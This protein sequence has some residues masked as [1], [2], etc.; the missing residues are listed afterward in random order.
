M[1]DDSDK[2]WPPFYPEELELPPTDTT[3]AAGGVYRFVEQT[4]PSRACFKTSHEESPLRYKRCL[5]REA[6]ES[7]YG[8]SFWETKSAALNKL[9][10]FPEALG[11]K[12]LAYGIL[13]DTMGLMKHTLE[14]EH[15][16]VWFRIN[17]KPHLNFSEVK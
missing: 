14:P 7:V 10:I 6:K 17:A 16:T 3:P 4:P 8:T 15:I 1:T 12:I 11:N 9:K 5:T 2:D 13:D